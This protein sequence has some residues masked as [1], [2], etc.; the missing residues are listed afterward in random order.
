MLDEHTLEQ[1]ERE[2]SFIEKDLK[3]TDGALEKEINIALYA[4]QL[5]VPTTKTGYFRGSEEK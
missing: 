4:E 1:A 5:G 3:D 2:L